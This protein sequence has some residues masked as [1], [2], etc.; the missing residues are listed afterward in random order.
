MRSKTQICVTTPPM[1]TLYGDQSNCACCPGAVSKR[2]IAR[3]LLS[4]VLGSSFGAWGILMPIGVAMAQAAHVSLPLLIG[5]VFAAG[6][7]GG[8]VSPFS[9]ST[10]IMAQIMDLD[11][12]AYSR[13]KLKH[14]LIPLLLAFAG[15]YLVRAL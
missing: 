13:Y 8:L 1:V 14:S 7:F 11:L 5:A 9:D 15:F 2:A 6:T 4:Y 12:M 3:S 10:V